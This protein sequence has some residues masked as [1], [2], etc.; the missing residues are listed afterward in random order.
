M[1]GDCQM[2]SSLWAEWEQTFQIVTFTVELKSQ[3]KPME[4]DNKE[5]L[6]WSTSVGSIKVS[7]RRKNFAEVNV[8]HLP[9]WTSELWPC[10]SKPPDWRIFGTETFDLWQ[11]SL[12]PKTQMH[13]TPHA[14]KYEG[15]HVEESKTLQ[16]LSSLGVFC[17]D[18][19]FL[20]CHELSTVS[21]SH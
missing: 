8:M 19:S 11:K 14:G 15:H 4:D 6:R 17:H 7:E 18:L 12:T 1:S 9:Q 20:I 21:Q 5:I 10:F 16:M 13:V 2:S 3:N